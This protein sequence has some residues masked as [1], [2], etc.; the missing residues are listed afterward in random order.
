VSVGGGSVGT[1][2][3]SPTWAEKPVDLTKIDCVSK[4]TVPF[5]V[6]GEMGCT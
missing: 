2:E 1:L 6:Y 4:E 3:F 5:S